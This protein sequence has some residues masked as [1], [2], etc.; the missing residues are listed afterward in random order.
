[1]AN[2]SRETLT[3]DPTFRLLARRIWGCILWVMD[4]RIKNAVGLFIVIAA[5]VFTYAAS[6]YVHTY[7]KSVNPA[8]FR[9]FAVSAEGK[10][11]AIPDV[12]QFTL[13]VIVEGGKDVGALQKENSEKMNRINAF[14]KSQ[15][16]ADAD[17]KTTN[18]NIDPRYQYYNCT[19]RGPC[20]PPEIVGYTINQSVQVKIRDF[21]KIG[22]LLSGVVANGANSVS[23]LTFTI[24]DPTKVQ[25]E[26]RA[27]AIVKAREKAQGLA[28]AGGF[29]LGKLLSIE[30]SSN[31]P[32]SLYPVF[33]GKGMGGGGGGPVIEPGSQEISISVVLKYEMR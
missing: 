15:Q 23:Q 31:Q 2:E 1:M 10:A 21:A 17:V 16:V 18:Y 33:E 27:E 13:S 26:A 32:P 3:K 25:N 29:R 7:S 28:R 12:A 22:D 5:A 8:S 24:D 20:P 4:E 30:E 11:V 6:S 14:L 19:E 9:S